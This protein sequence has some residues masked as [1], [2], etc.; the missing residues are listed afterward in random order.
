[1]DALPADLWATVAL[2]LKLASLTTIALLIVGTPLAWRLA[3]SRSWLGEAVAAVV[4]LPLVLP[5][6]ACARAGRSG[7]L[8]GG[9]VGRAHAR[10]HL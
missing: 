9:P 6:F 3:R 1:M 10:L 5:P 4:A 8:A 7:R 2:T